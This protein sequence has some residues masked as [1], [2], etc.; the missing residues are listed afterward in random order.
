[1]KK[2]CDVD[3]FTFFS[4][5]FDENIFFSKTDELLLI[6]DVCCCLLLLVLFVVVVVLPFFV[7]QNLKISFW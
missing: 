1:M 7:A 6:V 4:T 2:Q 3:F 5:N